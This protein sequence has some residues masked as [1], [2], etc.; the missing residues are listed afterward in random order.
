M[1]KKNQESRTRN[2]AKKGNIWPISKGILKTADFASSNRFYIL[3]VFFLAL[4]SWF[5]VLI[6]NS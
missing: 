6:S 2:Q 4:D 1:R 5:L 3:Y